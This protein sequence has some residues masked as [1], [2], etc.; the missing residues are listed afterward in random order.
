[1]NRIAQR[2][3]SALA[4]NEGKN[5]FDRALFENLTVKSCDVVGKTSKVV[6]EL[7]LLAEWLN[8]DGSLH[9]GAIST[10][11]D[12]T[13]SLSIAAVDERNSVSVDLSVSFISALKQAHVMEIEA[14]C[15]K[16]G[17]SLAFTSAEIR[18]NGNIIAT[19][20]HTKYMMTPA[21]SGN[22]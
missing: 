9:G 14:V 16:L 4:K 17:K 5:F 18:A 10:L 20:K 22:S 3:A 19:G 15:H 8:S 21:P 6:I 7:P 12:Q 1:M 2:I 13:T 11:I